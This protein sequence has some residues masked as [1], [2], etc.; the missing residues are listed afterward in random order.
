MDKAN[1]WDM[2]SAVRESKDRL[3][4]R[5]VVRDFKRQEPL[6]RPHKA[7]RIR[8][9]SDTW[10]PGQCVMLGA[11]MKLAHRSLLFS[12]IAA[13]VAFWAGGC[14]AWYL[15]G[16]LGGQM[17][18]V[19]KHLDAYGTVTMSAPLFARADEKFEFNLTANADEFYKDARSNIQGAAAQSTE[20]SFLASMFLGAQ[21][22]PTLLSQFLFQQQQF[23]QNQSLQS[24]ADALRLQ[25]AQ[26]G[27]R[28]DLQAAMKETDPIVRQQKIAEAQRKYAD[29]IA[30]ASR[31]APPVADS[32]QDLPALPEGKAKGLID[33]GK[34]LSSDKFLPPGD[35]IKGKNTVLSDRAALIIAAGDNA[36]KAIFSVLG[37]PTRSTHF[38]GKKV[39]FA[40]S[41]VS[42]N[43]GWRTRKDYTANITMNVS[44]RLVPARPEI[45]EAIT[46]PADLGVKNEEE[47]GLLVRNARQVSLIPWES[48]PAGTESSGTQKQAVRVDLEVLRL[49]KI[50]DDGNRA[51]TESQARVMANLVRSMNS[52]EVLEELQVPPSGPLVAA[53]AP[54]NDAQVLDLQ[55]SRRDQTA[56]GLE[57]AGALRSAGLSAQADVLTQYVKRRQSDV[58]T[59]S[60]NVVANAYSIAGGH[61]GF[62]IGPSLR[63]IAHPSEYS[64]TADVLTR[65]SFPVLLTIGL[66]NPDL[67]PRVFTRGGVKIVV[68]P[69]LV[70]TQ[71]SCWHPLSFWG[72]RWSDVKRLD[73]ARQL[74]IVR[75]EINKLRRDLDA[76]GV[77]AS[78]DYE[79]QA[80][81]ELAEARVQTLQAEVSGGVTYQYLPPSFIQFPHFNDQEPKVLELLPAKVTLK[82]DSATGNPVAKTVS[83]HLIGNNLKKVDI[84]GI[85]I[86]GSG[87]ATLAARWMANDIVVDVPFTNADAP[88]VLEMPVHLPKAH[89]IYSLPIAVN[90]EA[91]PP[92]KPFIQ[93]TTTPPGVDRLDFQGVS[94]DVI[95]A[96]IEKSKPQP[97]KK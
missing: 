96:E 58:S 68:E 7:K 34:P 69:Q 66:E 89:S 90:L 1:A 10:I 40:V 62:E 82:T 28:A 2:K 59:R 5:I 4:L 83:V 6:A 37:D 21:F 76:P 61:F 93:R 87:A 24:Q 53:V 9:S 46:D 12:A 45:V 25:A 97:E 92:S 43:P 63:A 54:M 64:K 26:T 22:D 31:P 35:L 77:S 67:R 44:Y 74:A 3:D 48:Y 19:G 70:I 47:L 85:R 75:N 72:A 29:A 20:E 86:A 14:G 16:R 81:V 84:G 50:P 38:A 41:M 8:Q 27:Y 42:V 80:I 91:P 32:K 52:P 17:D 73:M 56:L 30:P 88:V 36:T 39:L 57:L 78:V 79:K 13:A 33:T 15:P 65:Q 94:D 60:E 23:S 18:S 51:D 11:V 55:N 95:K 71:T 49:S